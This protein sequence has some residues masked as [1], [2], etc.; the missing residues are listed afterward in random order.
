MRLEELDDNRYQLYN[1]PANLLIKKDIGFMFSLYVVF[2]MHV[3][4]FI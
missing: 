2:I 1:L 3:V 4:K